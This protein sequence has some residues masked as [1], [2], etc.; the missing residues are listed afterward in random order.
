MVDTA[1]C[2]KCASEISVEADRCPECGY[3]PSKSGLIF[4]ILVGISVAS[5]ILFGGLI[6]I[7]WLVVIAGTLSITDALIGTGFFGL[8]LLFSIS[9]AYIGLKKGTKTPTGKHPNS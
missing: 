4:S 7:L 1:K 8:I 3:E 9:I 5:S 6:L 2:E